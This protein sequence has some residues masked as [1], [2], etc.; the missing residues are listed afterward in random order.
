MGGTYTVRRQ[1][2]KVHLEVFMN[3]TL[4]SVCALLIC[5]T[6]APTR[7]QSALTTEADPL[8][9][10]EFMIGRWEGTSAGQPGAAKVQREYTRILNSRFIRVQ[11][12]SVYAPQYKNPE[13]E[14]HEDLGVFSFDASRRRAVLRQFH[15][16]GFV[17]QYIA[18]L[19]PKPAKLEFTSEAIENIPAGWRARETYVVFGPDEFEEVFELAGP[20]KP[21]ELY[22]R[23]RLKRVR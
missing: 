4:L 7:A 18:D 17:N 23:V 13:G 11:N 21:F 22:S 6:P 15:V 10:L 9:P 5:A 19:G 3:C 20:G 1:C 8:Q 16:E 12:K 2:V 14:T